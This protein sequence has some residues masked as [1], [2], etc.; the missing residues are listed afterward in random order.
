M[1]KTSL[2]TVTSQI[3]RDLRTYLERVRETLE[4]VQAAQ[5]SLEVTVNGG[6]GGGGGGW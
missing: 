1:A 6:G 5:A 2:P 4:S 3:P